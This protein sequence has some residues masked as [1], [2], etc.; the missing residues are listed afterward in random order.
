VSRVPARR[1]VCLHGLGRAASDW[2]AVRPGL[3][4]F[5]PVRCPTLP[6]AGDDALAAA[7]AATGEGAILVGHSMGA[8]IALRLAADPRRRVRA[9]VL[10]G[11]FFPPARNGRSTAASVADYAAHRVAYVR[12]AARQRGRGQGSRRGTAGALGSLI[13]LAIRPAAFDSLT[14][15]IEA[16]VIVLHARDDHHVPLD[17]ALGAAARRPAWALHVFE[18]GGHHVHVD[19][20]AEWLEPVTTWLR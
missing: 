8:L 18:A 16:P 5:G 4:A 1:V 10:T 12:A 6:R 3:E 9:V 13:R 14:R 7:G 20:P 2:E 19:R 11:C 15:A 17:F